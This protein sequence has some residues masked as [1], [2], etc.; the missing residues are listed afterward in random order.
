MFEKQMMEGQAMDWSEE[1]GCISEEHLNYM[2]SLYPQED[3]SEDRSFHLHKQNVKQVRHLGQRIRQ[4]VCSKAYQI[5]GHEGDL[6]DQAV[7]MAESRCKEDVKTRPC[8]WDSYS[9]T[10]RRTEIN[11]SST[12]SSQKRKIKTRN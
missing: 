2:A 1:S 11:E 8:S 6:S 9:A 7:L 5:L 3:K 10:E 12:T 4:A